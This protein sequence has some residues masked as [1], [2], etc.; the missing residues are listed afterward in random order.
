MVYNR[1]NRTRKS[2]LLI[3]LKDYS[4]PLV[5]LGLILILIFSFFWWWDDTNPQD[6]ENR[7]W[8]DITYNGADSEVDIEYSWWDK[9]KADSETKLYKWEKIIVTEWSVSL[10]FTSNWT[11]TLNKYWE[12]KY[13]DEG[14]FN[15]DAWDLWWNIKDNSIIKMKYANLDI[16]GWTVLSLTQNEVESNVYVLKWVVEIS[17]I[18]WQSTVLWNWDKISITRND[19]ASEDVDLSLLKEEIDES[20]KTDDWFIKN[21]WE[22]YLTENVNDNDF[23][24]TW[25]TIDLN[26]NLSKN[27]LISLDDYRDEMT[28]DKSSI[29]ISW[30]YYDI[31]IAKITVNWQLANLD[32]KDSTFLISSVWLDKK[33]N[34]LVIKVYDDAND[35]LW[36]YVYT[37]YYNWWID[38]TSNNNTT[39]WW[40]KVINYK[41]DAADFKFTQPSTTWNFT[42]YDSFVTIRWSV[43]SKDISYITVN[44]YRLSSFNWNTWRYHAS[45]DNN[46]LIDW[47]NIYQ[48]KYYSEWGELIYSNTFTII[49]KSWSAPIIDTSVPKPKEENIIDTS[50]VNSWSWEEINKYSNE[51]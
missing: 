46:N 2:N 34:D 49:K 29:N 3:T 9:V 19:A 6:N 17:N 7:V 38:T 47:T 11:F 20:F 5:W 40:F 35:I 43:S 15:L 10:D 30:K 28:V 45:T 8:I 24:S 13:N 16:L 41:A 33:T 36:K 27:G 37:I 18:W 51:V 22:F 21:N 23:T 44:D 26:N 39:T 12:L 48:V 31:S 1:N 42:T 14:S 50:S 32:T 4:I 25:E